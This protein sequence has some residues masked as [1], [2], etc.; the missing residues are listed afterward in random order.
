MNTNAQKHEQVQRDWA[1]VKA[2]DLARRSGKAVIGHVVLTVVVPLIAG[3]EDVVT[4]R[5]GH[6]FGWD[7]VSY[8]EPACDP[9]SGL[10]TIT[11][12]ATVVA[13]EV[14]LAGV[15]P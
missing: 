15:T 4:S 14:K 12:P 2:R 5:A 9:M 3:D 11:R 10:V 6:P 7:N 13:V 8:S 1:E